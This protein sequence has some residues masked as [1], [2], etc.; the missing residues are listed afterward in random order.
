MAFVK[1]ITIE[2]NQVVNCHYIIITR[3]LVFVSATRVLRYTTSIMQQVTALLESYG[4]YLRLSSHPKHCNLLVN[5]LLYVMLVNGNVIIVCEYMDSCVELYKVMTI[6][7]YYTVTQD[8]HVTCY[9]ICHMYTSLYMSYVHITVHVTYTCHCTCHTSLY[10]SHV[11]V[12]VTVHVIH[13]C[14]CH[15]SL[16]MLGLCDNLDKSI[17]EIKS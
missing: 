5:N 16:Y 3:P 8:V 2:S 11:T 7:N 4:L 14:T 15:L 6:F 17:I 12:Y 1:K 13:H 10:M 9:C